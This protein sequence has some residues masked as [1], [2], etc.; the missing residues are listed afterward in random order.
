M[1]EWT[2]GYIVKRGRA[3]ERWEGG[4][5]KDE[6][7]KKSVNKGRQEKWKNFLYYMW[8]TCWL[9]LKQIFKLFFHQV[10]KG[11]AD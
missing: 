10:C 9:L 5:E 3:E 2:M 6:W 8:S 7:W 4:K 1:E 11:T